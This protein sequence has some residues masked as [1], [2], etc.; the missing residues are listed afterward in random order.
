MGLWEVPLHLIPGSEKIDRCAL[1]VMA[2]LVAA[3]HVFPNRT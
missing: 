2:A 1:C 3:I